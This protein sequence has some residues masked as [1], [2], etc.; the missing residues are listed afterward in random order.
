MAID[1]HRHDYPVREGEMKEVPCRMPPPSPLLKEEGKQ[2]L[3]DGESQTARRT[4][5]VL[6]KVLCDS[7]ADCTALKD[8]LPLRSDK[9]DRIASN[10]AN[11]PVHPG[12]SNRSVIAPLEC[13]L[14]FDKDRKNVSPKSLGAVECDTLLETI[15]PARDTDG[16]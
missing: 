9:K 6:L 11:R 4:L 8:F 1:A 5:S 14:A 12:S 3:N 10:E 13:I 2:Q 16:S 15:S 7:L